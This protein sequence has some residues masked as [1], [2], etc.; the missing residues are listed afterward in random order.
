MLLADT[1]PDTD[2]SSTDAVAAALSHHEWWNGQGYPYG[3][4]G[5][6][7]PRCARIIAVADVFDALV[8]IRPYKPAWRMPA[9]LEHMVRLRGTQF[10]P[11]CIDALVEVAHDL[12]ATWQAVAQA[13]PIY[14]CHHPGHAH[15]GVP[16]APRTE[17][18]C[19]SA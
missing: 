7:I 8:S 15:G 11:D 10:D 16:A 1:P 5:R 18:A 17:E 19:L 2:A 12:P 9:A 14:P 13:G 4:S 3:L 6:A